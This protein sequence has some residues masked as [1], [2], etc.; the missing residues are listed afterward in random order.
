MQSNLYANIST[1]WKCKSRI[2]FAVSCT[3]NESNGKPVREREREE[4]GDRNR[5]KLKKIAII[6]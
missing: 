6:A 5:K 4:E 1:Y 2:H 3:T